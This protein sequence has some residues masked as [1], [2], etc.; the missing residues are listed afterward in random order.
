MSNPS[1][2]PQQQQQPQSSGAGATPRYFAV[3][4]NPSSS[5]SSSNKLKAPALFFDANDLDAFLTTQQ[6]QGG[7]NNSHVETASFA[8]M[9][10]AVQY[11]A[12]ALPSHID[13]AVAKAAALSLSSAT[14]KKRSA[15]A[16]AASSS[17]KKQKKPKPS[18]HH[19]APP[20]GTAKYPFPPPEP[21]LVA[22]GGAAQTTTN[23]NS[24]AAAAAAAAPLM[25]PHHNVNMNIN[26]MAPHQHHPH[27]AGPGGAA[28]AYTNAVSGGSTTHNNSN[29]PPAMVLAHAADSVNQQQNNHNNN[30]P[31]HKTP[32]ELESE[33]WELMFRRLDAHVQQYGPDSL[34]GS[35]GT[36]GISYLYDPKLC[37]W[38]RD[39]QRLYNLLEKG[40]TSS[41]SISNIN[42]V[43]TYKR[44]QRL[45]NL[46][47]DFDGKKNPPTFEERAQE[48]YGKYLILYI[49]LQCVFLL[50]HGPVQL[51]SIEILLDYFQEHKRDPPSSNPLNKWV[52]RI[53]TSYH[54]LMSGKPST[55]TP[56][57]IH[58]L[59]SYGFRFVTK[60]TNQKLNHKVKKWEERYEE[61]KEHQRVHGDCL[62]PQTEPSGLGRWV[63]A[64]RAQYK[65]LSQGERSFLTDDKIAKLQAIG[66]VFSTKVD[67]NAPPVS[68]DERYQQLVKY[69]ELHP[70]QSVHVP[71]S[72]PGLGRWCHD[73]RKAAR[74]RQLPLAR[75]ER[76]QALGFDFDYKVQ[77]NIT[78]TKARP[79]KERFDQLVDYKN[80]HNGSTLVPKDTPELGQWVWKQRTDYRKL[81]R[82][83]Q[84]PL[85]A[86]K[87]QLLN[88]IGFVWQ[89]SDEQKRA[90]YFV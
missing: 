14:T 58:Q 66:F 4:P 28:V 15:A 21:I 82:G 51:M 54:Q 60:L 10:D 73:Q 57:R 9:V 43:L 26:P 47:Y 40:G 86:E 50:L 69:K 46:G 72:Y 24:T 63:Q 37:L 55:L 88:S 7:N 32:L 33:Q 45:K 68:W 81:Q 35:T 36:G 87:V 22:A 48:W 56:E 27:H 78:K 41:S 8:T 49:R 62:V 25:N 18:A 79:W 80:Q 65:K 39:Q 23:S 85:T 38:L 64:Q 61:L 3:K 11:I 20:S 59:E 16:S 29:M 84:S 71:L 52:G 75:R 74:A 6:H 30:N 83:E 2:A 34:D 17:K 44:I 76:L 90:S 19:T 70:Q 12:S 53:R 89:L 5:A 42:G 31:F 67:A 1:T 13:P 77:K